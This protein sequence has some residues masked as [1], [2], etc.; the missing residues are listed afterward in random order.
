VFRLLEHFTQ[1]SPRVIDGLCIFPRTSKAFQRLRW[2][3]FDQQI[4]CPFALMLMSLMP[5]RTLGK[6]LKVVGNQLI[7][8]AV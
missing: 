5:A 3:E 7:S 6:E 2:H 1:A 8:A 4:G